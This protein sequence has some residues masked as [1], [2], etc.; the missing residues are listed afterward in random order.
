M[1]LEKIHFDNVD[2]FVNYLISVMLETLKA[3]DTAV[4]VVL[5]KTSKTSFVQLQIPVNVTK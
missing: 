1:V 4:T 2:K 5:C 3:R